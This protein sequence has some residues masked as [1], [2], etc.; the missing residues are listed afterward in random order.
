MV[1]YRG[2]AGSICKWSIQTK[3]IRG[4]EI[5]GQ[6]QVDKGLLRIKQ[7]KAKQENVREGGFRTNN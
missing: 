6:M 1:W 3:N 7:N 4:P 2:W 5:C